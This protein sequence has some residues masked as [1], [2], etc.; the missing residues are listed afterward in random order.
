[1]AATATCVGDRQSR[2]VVDGDAQVKGLTVGSGAFGAFDFAQEWRGNAVAAAD[3]FEARALLAEPF[4][5]QAKKGADDP[6]DAS[7]F[8]RGARPV[9]GRECVEC[10]DTDAKPWRVF[11]GAP[12]CG[13]ASAMTGDAWQPAL[14]GP[15]AVAV[16]NDG[17]VESGF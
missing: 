13:D 16:H 17:D 8:L 3:D 14:R 11:D 15:A 7:H 6:E 4:A 1:M 2:G 10:E 5:L 12:Y 9:V